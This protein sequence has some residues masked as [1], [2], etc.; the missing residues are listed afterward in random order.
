MLK[1]QKRYLSLLS[2]R[3]YLQSTNGYLEAMRAC[4]AQGATLATFPQSPQQNMA[5]FFKWM[6]TNYNIQ[7]ATQ[8]VDTYNTGTCLLIGAYKDTLTWQ[9]YWETTPLQ[10]IDSSLWNIAD[11]AGWEPH[12]DL[13]HAC[14]IP[15][16]FTSNASREGRYNTI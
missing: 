16:S 10:P 13:Y 6:A 9:W 4:V 15:V 1:N 3:P 5:N 2:Y 12:N 14:V 8:P 11:N 7:L